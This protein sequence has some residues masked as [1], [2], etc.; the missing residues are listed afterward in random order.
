MFAIIDVE[1]SGNLNQKERITEI[2]ICVFDGL[3]VVE[4]FE[5]LVNPQRSID[6]FVRKITGITDEMV[7]DKPTFKELAQQIWTLTNGNIFT[8][9]NAG[10]DFPIVRREFQ[11]IGIDFQRPRLCTVQAARKFIPGMDKYGL[12]NLCK[13][14]RITNTAPHRALGDVMATLEVLKIIIQN[15]QRNE[16]RKL[17]KIN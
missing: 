7:R 4:T 9:H 14:L 17:V 6:P 3:G 10:F 12:E 2:A 15:D 11:S 5:S 1:T 16:L 13:Q 8:A